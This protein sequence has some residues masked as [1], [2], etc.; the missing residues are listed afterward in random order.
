YENALEYIFYYNGMTSTELKKFRNLF[1]RTEK[2]INMESITEDEALEKMDEISLYDKYV[3]LPEF[4][5]R[6]KVL[7]EK[8]GL[9]EG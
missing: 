8:V 3:R 7:E 9:T 4:Y 5:Q 2:A 6:F 1:E